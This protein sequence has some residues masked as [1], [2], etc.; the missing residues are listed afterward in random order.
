MLVVDN[1]GFDWAYTGVYR[2]KNKQKAKKEEPAFG[3]F[4]RCENTKLNDRPLLSLL[5]ILP[6]FLKEEVTFLLRRRLIKSTLNIRSY[7]KTK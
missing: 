1:I 4:H 7:A 5:L 2:T 6:I 3:E